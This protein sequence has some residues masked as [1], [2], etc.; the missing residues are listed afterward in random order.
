MASPSTITERVAEMRA[1]MA[2][3]PRNEAMDAGR[4]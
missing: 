2:A 4:A 1:V 3:Q